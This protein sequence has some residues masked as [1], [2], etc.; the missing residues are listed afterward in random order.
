MLR[1]P[2]P[3]TARNS[4][5][6]MRRSLFL[7]LG[8][9]IVISASGCG[10]DSAADETATVAATAAATSGA[11]ELDVSGRVILRGEGGLQS[12]LDSVTVSFVPE[13]GGEPYT[14]TT[15]DAGQFSLRAP[16]GTYEV[17][18]EAIAENQQFETV[19]VSL[20]EGET[21]FAIP[22]LTVEPG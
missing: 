20:P 9:A 21:S 5:G 2:T 16:A 19:E 3:E 15:D 1:C 18:L 8:V 11:N 6:R 7:A 12:P 13:D 4:I 10:G 17:Q 14:A 22:P